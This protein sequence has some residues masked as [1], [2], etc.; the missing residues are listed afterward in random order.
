MGNEIFNAFTD[1]LIKISFPEK[2]GTNNSV[3]NKGE[4]KI[5]ATVADQYIEYP[6]DV[7]RKMKFPK[8]RNLKFP[9]LG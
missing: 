3:K 5:D 1:E 7:K 4:M 9:G 8:K 2:I 6:N